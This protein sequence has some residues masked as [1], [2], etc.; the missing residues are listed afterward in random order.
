[1]GSVVTALGGMDLALDRYPAEVQQAPGY[2]RN[3]MERM[4]YDEY[5]AAGYPIGSGTVESGAN[6]VVH[7]RMKRPGRG[8]KM[9]NA[10]AMLAGL[11]ELK[12]G[13][14]ELAWQATLPEAA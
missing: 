7:H 8:W 12:S 1:V 13:R 4:R 9:G 3:N 10:Q 5:R 14:F 11:S 6:S 2:F